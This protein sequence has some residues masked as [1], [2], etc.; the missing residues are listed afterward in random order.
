[1]NLARY[2]PHRLRARYLRALRVLPG[3]A[4]VP[5]PT[6]ETAPE[7]APETVPELT[8]GP[9]AAPEPM[10]GPVDP[11]HLTVLG[12]AWINRQRL[13]FGTHTD[14][15]RMWVA[16]CDPHPEA[17]PSMIG[18]FTGLVTDEID[19]HICGHEHRAWVSE[20]EHTAHLKRAAARIW[21]DCQRHCEG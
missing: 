21:T 14:A 17:E 8:P 16:F 4:P 1:M 19:L 5:E 12:R 3:P 18:Y 7:T 11:R 2:A 15:P 10:P 6:P 13:I 9:E 20:G